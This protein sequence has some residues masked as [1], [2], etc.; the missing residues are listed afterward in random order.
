MKK[1]DESALMQIFQE[2]ATPSKMLTVKVC[3]EMVFFREWSLQV[4][5]SL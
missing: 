1:Y 2:Y 4:F 5:H 3:S